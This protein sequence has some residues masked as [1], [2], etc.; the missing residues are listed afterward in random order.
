MRRAYCARYLAT[1][2][3]AQR[4]R[5]KLISFFQTAPVDIVPEARRCAELPYQMVPPGW[6]NPGDGG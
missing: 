4:V 6:S 3:E 1:P 5:H 2:I